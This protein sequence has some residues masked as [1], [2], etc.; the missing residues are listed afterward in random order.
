MNVATETA[1]RSTTCVRC[2]VLHFLPLKFVWVGDE[3]AARYVTGTPEALRRL[4]GRYVTS[5]RPSG[6]LFSPRT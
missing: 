6:F 3:M 5:K 4:A 2:E 1:I